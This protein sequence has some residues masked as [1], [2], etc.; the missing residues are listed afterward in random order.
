MTTLG[1]VALCLSSAS[2]YVWLCMRKAGIG[3]PGGRPDCGCG[4]GPACNTNVQKVGQTIKL[5]D[6]NE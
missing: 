4:N 1:F 5:G 2:I 3:Q 6:N